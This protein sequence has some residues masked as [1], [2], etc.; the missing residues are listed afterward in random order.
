MADPTKLRKITRETQQSR[1]LKELARG[2]LLGVFEPGQ[3]LSIRELT[4]Q[5]GA[6]TMPVRESIQRLVGLGAVRALPNRT[7]QVPLLVAKQF[8]ELMEVRLAL[9]P[10]ATMKAAELCTAEDVARFKSLLAG[11]RETVDHGDIS[12]QL[13][14]N[15]RLHFAVY[16]AARAPYLFS[17]IEG[18]WLRLGPLLRVIFTATGEV[19]DSE[20]EELWGL[21]EGW[22]AGI[23]A[24]DAETSR[25]A[26][27][28]IITRAALWYHDHYAFP[29]ESP[30]ET[31]PLIGDDIL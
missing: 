21:H 19:G 9:E 8:D 2:L 1:A 16:E 29:E 11:L 4:E 18:L 7:L 26:L 25:S 10:L 28:Q 31:P 12:Q 5:I 14:A 24:H 30:G 27:E 22:I 3:T 17:A 13:T 6:G 15:A 20:L 23:A